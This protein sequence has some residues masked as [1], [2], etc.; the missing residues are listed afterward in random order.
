[1]L[2]MREIAIN[3]IRNVKPIEKENMKTMLYHGVVCGKDYAQLN[4]IDPEQLTN[5]LKLIFKG[6]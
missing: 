3:Y 2:S 4:G 1:M 6:E 5:E